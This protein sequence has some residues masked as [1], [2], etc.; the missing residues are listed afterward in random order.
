M[1]MKQWSAGLLWLGLAA[2]APLLGQEADPAADP[3]AAAVDEEA[4]SDAP[5]AT[6]AETVP[7]DGED[8]GDVLETDDESYLDI[9]QDEFKPSEEI[10]LDQSIAFPTDI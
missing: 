5:L 10:P 7:D 8:G 1:Q 4:A 3:A 9:E 2:T 6:D